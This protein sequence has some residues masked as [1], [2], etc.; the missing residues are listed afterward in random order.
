MLGTVVGNASNDREAGPAL[1]AVD[2][3][4]AVAAVGRVEELT[5]AV[6]AG[7]D[8]GWDQRR[9]ARGDALDDPELGLADRRDRLGRQRAHR[10]DRGCAR[11]ELAGERVQLGALDLDQD[12]VAV[13]QHVPAEAVLTGKPV[14]ERPK[15]HTLDDAAGAQPASLAGVGSGRLWH[16]KSMTP[17]NW[18][19]TVGSRKAARESRRRSPAG[20]RCRAGARIARLSSMT[21]VI[22]VAALDVLV[23][24]LSARGYTV[25]GPTVRDGAIVYEE[26]D[27]AAALPTGWTDVQDG[28][29]YRLERRTTTR[30]SAT[31]SAPTSWK[32]FLFPPR[33]RLW[34]ATQDGDGLRGRGGAG[35]RRARSPSSA[36]APASWPRSRIQDRVFLGGRY[37]DRDYAA[38]REDAFLVAVNCHEPAGTCFCVSMDTGPTARD[39]YDLVLTE[40]L[41]GGHRFLVEA[42]SERGEEVLG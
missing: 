19:T 13:V 26:L 42:G 8:V 14:H 39:G 6:V 18:V 24:A 40:L 29:F 11:D 1:R 38:R 15:A 4:V 37:V 32:R 36:S 22:D 23:A 27:S 35:R 41:E 12:S 16:G 7:G 30:A 2:E 21:C 5:Q 34:K 31:P 25:V 20:S 10:G 33:V 17:I 3:R 9:M 28:G